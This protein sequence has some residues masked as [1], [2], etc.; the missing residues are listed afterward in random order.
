MDKIL[1][2][3]HVSQVDPR[4]SSSRKLYSINTYRVTYKSVFSSYCTEWR[5]ETIG[6]KEYHSKSTIYHFAAFLYLGNRFERRKKL[7]NRAATNHVTFSNEPENN[8]P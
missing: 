1:F 4:I 5:P 7:V 2:F 8:A 3:T 6:R